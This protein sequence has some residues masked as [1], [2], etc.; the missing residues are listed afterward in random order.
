MKKILLTGA[1][2]F[3]GYHV[4]AYLLQNKH[5]VIAP[6]RQ[7]SVNNNNISLLKD[8]GL[9]IIEGFFYADDVLKQA[10][11][12]SLDGVIHLAAIRGEQNVPPSQYQRVNVEGTGRL[13][14]LTVREK[15]PK[16]IYGSSVGVYGTIPREQPAGLRTSLQ[17]DN[18]YH[19]SKREAERLVEAAHKSGLNTI[20]LRPT[21]TYGSGDNGFIPK[22]VRM[23]RHKRFPLSS[24]P[25]N[26]HLL[27]VNALAQL[28]E[29]LLHR[30]HFDGNA[31]IVA[32]R[33][34]VSLKQIAD[35]VFHQ[36]Y[37]KP[38]PAVLRFPAA[39]FRVGETF[40]KLT[41]QSRLLTSLRLIS[42]SWTY[43][44]SQ[45]ITQL[46][47]NPQPTMESIL[48]VIKEILHAR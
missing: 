8:K 28:M 19:R 38:Y 20:I 9:K 37:Q 15:V 5:R 3:I 18:L 40:L 1:S 31:Y 6:V 16:F 21:V 13:L 45:T 27:S 23:V 14:R 26:I 44:I 33:E 29:K 36:A 24:R 48:P 17:P 35:A 47:Y 34:P 11:A 7:A 30:N 42:R 39:G 22:L 4:A 10:F 46:E 12:E 25:V 2:G 41:G 43:D 32:D